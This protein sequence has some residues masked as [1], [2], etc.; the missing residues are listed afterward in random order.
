MG[1]HVI[2][3]H[4]GLLCLGMCVALGACADASTEST[5]KEAADDAPAEVAAKD[6][7]PATPAEKPK[8][9]TSADLEKPLSER[10]PPEPPK[11]RP[12]QPGMRPEKA[13]DPTP[14]ADTELIVLEAGTP[15]VGRDGRLKESVGIEAMPGRFVATLKPGCEAPCWKGA[16]VW[17]RTADEPTLDVT[18]YR[19][20]GAFT[21]KATKIGKYRIG[22]IPTG[23]PR[24]ELLLVFGVV[25][26]ALKAYARV[27]DDGTQLS[28]R[29]VG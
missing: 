26:G 15:A 14:T 3:L 22:D 28:L 27:R 13:V 9:F 29:P 7:A 5:E 24:K 19:G 10:P 12:H 17:T 11:D 1:H 23:G 2:R 25:D 8:R 6:Q 18:V 20:K 4:R 16:R 21:N